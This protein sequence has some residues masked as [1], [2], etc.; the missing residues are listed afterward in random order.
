[1]GAEIDWQS[2]VFQSGWLKKFDKLATKR[3]G[4]GGLAEEASTYVI[5]KIS[6]NQWQCFATFKGQCKPESYLY[7]VTSNYLEEFSRKRF[8][9]PRPPDW[10]KRQGALWV[11]IWKMVCLERQLIQSVIEQ[12]CSKSLRETNVIKNAIITIKARLPWCGGDSHREVTKNMSD[13]DDYDPTELI[14]SRETPELVV[15]EAAYTESLLLISSLMN[16]KPVEQMFGE[17][18]SELASSYVKSNRLK[19]DQIQQKLNLTDEEKILLRMIFQDGMKKSVIAKSLGM[20]EH[21]PGRI[22]KQLLTRIDSVFS[23]L[24]IDL[25]EVYETCV[26]FSE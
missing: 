21:L 14:T 12:L 9:R 10:L 17:R 4:E 3:F 15:T 1:M 7:T 26:E 25:T 16:D 18:T 8:G 2:L 5:D 24:N 11:Q 23:E 22:L 20:Q 6:S 19:I 13:M